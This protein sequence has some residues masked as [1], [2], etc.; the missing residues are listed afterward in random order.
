MAAQVETWRP[1][2]SLPE[3]LASSHGRLMRIPWHGAMPKGG[4]KTYGG[5]PTLGAWSEQDC[6]YVLQFRGQTYKVAR[7]VCEAFHGPQPDD[8]PVCMHLD[9]NSRNNRPENLAWGTQKEN[10]NAPGYLEQLRTRRRAA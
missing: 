7:L 10:L 8:K 6:R 2:P 9:E 1:I 3:Y 4:V 5:Q